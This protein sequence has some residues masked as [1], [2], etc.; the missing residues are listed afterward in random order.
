MV[1]GKVAGKAIAGGLRKAAKTKAGKGAQLAAAANVVDEVSDNKYV[2][3]SVGA[4]EGA[5]LGAAFGPAGAVGGA[6]VG[7]AVGFL[8]ADGERIAPV[9]LVAIP[10]YQYSAMLAGREPTFQLYIKEG[11][12]I[13]PTAPTDYQIGG[14]I[15]LAEEV[16]QVGP[17][18]RKL[19]AWQ[20]YIKQD[21]NK[22]YYKSGPKK[23]RLNFSAMSKKYKRG[24][25]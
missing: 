10:A 2:Q 22:I 18:K 16:E 13:S 4:L 21:K 19:S 15:A 5:A 11:E 25:K 8:L 12:M 9:D 24:K 3:A 14:A 17:P 23:G 1:K 7:G 20:R 6:I